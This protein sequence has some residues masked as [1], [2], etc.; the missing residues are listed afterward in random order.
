MTDTRLL[1]FLFLVVAVLLS[2]TGELFF[3]KG[4]DAI[5][6]I[7]FTL[8][9]LVRTFLTWQVLVG[10]VLFFAGSIV[11]LKVLS[12][13]DLGW[14][15]PM[16][17]LG[18]PLVVVESSLLLGEK[19]DPQRLLGSLV[20]LAGVF[21]MYHSWS[22]STSSDKLRGGDEPGVVTS[23]PSPAPPPATGG[24]EP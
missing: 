22:G 20:I 1:P 13:V 5:G 14:A 16:L 6:G 19:W 18:Y 3:K 17:A 12:L 24:G 8:P 23:T 15:Y 10:F 21:I 9:G 11:W 7:E 4:M 2:T